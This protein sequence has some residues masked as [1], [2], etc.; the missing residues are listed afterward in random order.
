V[1]ADVRKVLVNDG[2]LYQMDLVDASGVPE[3][4]FEVDA[5]GVLRELYGNCHVGEYRPLVLHE[6]EGWRP[7]V[8]VVSRDLSYWFIVEVET[9]NHSMEKHVLPQVRAFR[10]GYYGEEAAVKLGRLVGVDVAQ[11][12]SVIEYVPRH[13][14]VVAN[15]SDPSWAEKLAL[16]N[17]QFIGIDVFRRPE[18]W[19]GYLVSGALT[20]P[21]KSLGIGVVHASLHGIS[22]PLTGA[23]TWCSGLYKITSPHGTSTWECAVDGNRVWLCKARG[24][25]EF[26]DRSYVQVIGLEDGTLLLRRLFG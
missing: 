22:L 19:K 4:E 12:R 6:G 13:V 8:A 15:H 11:A 1:G 14:A 20:S 10:D 5:L 3:A 24:V 2:T 21:E 17:I 16:E 9:I 18:A 23:S 7:D 26:E 25:V